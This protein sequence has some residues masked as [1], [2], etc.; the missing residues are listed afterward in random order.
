MLIV[1]QAS[2]LCFRTHISNGTRTAEGTGT[3]E[4]FC[5]WLTPVARTGRA[6]ASNILTKFAAKVGSQENSWNQP[7]LLVG[8][9][10]DQLSILTK[11]TNCGFGVHSNITLH[12]HTNFIYF[13]LS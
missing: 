9:L 10:I 7:E 4:V 13:S 8:E 11:V 5:L 12:K 2:R 3:W 6:L 1:A